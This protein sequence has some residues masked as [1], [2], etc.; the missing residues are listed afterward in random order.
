MIKK[1]ILF[2]LLFLLIPAFLNAQWVSDTLYYEFDEIEVT[3]TKTPRMLSEIPGRVDVL[4]AE[5]MAS[6]PAVNLVYQ[7]RTLSG[8]NTSGS[9]GLFT[10]SPNVTLRGLSGEEQSRTLVMMDG[11]PLNK[12]DTGGVNWNSIN[13]A[14]VKQVEVYK[15]PGSSLYGSNAMGGVI[16]IITKTPDSPFSANAGLSYGTYNTYQGNL[17]VS[18]KP[19]EKLTL[20]LDGFYVNSDGYISTPDS[21]RS[22]FDAARFVDEGGFSAKA[23]Y[24]FSELFNVQ[25]GYD[26]FLNKRGDGTQITGSGMYR[27]FDTNRARFNVRGEQD[28]F[29]Y[30]LNMFFQREDYF[31]VS[32]RMRNGDYS[33]FNVES[34]RD[35]WGV[36]LDLFQDTGSHSLAGGIEF[37]TGS[38]DGGDFYQTSDDVVINRGSMSYLSGY[39]Q[40]EI[41]MLDR[42]LFLQL[43]LRY[44]YV[45]FYDGFFEAT[46]PRLSGYN[47]ELD[48]NNWSTIS[49]RAALR[50]NPENRSFSGYISYA[51][52]FRASILDDLSR[53]GIL[54]GR[55]K[56]ANPELG[57]ETLD[58]FEIGMDLRPVW[59]MIIS[60]SLFYSHG[61]DF[62]Y[63]VEMPDD[64]SVFRRE[65]VSS[66]QIAGA[67]IDLRYFVSNAVTIT[68]SYTLH[69]SE[70]LSFPERP[71]MEGNQL[72]FT[73]R[74]QLKSSLNWRNRIADIGFT[75]LYKGS[76]Y[77]SDD[78][79]QKIDPYITF[80]IM[81]SRQ[82]FDSMR[83]SLEV[84]DIMDNRFMES[85]VDMS[86]GRFI[87]FK[88]GYE[89]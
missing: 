18:S 32:E 19:T 77:I 39:L 9:F 64:D 84:M 86:P 67:E 73:P 58:N 55:D 34:E 56:I 60:P 61:N 78:N 50:F 62:L 23:G 8:I 70:I 57:P 2:I 48:S 54:W 44:D 16:N 71:D 76:Q 89:W 14:N 1:L 24:R 13:T 20:H 83:V 42:R 40:D 17:N 3:A 74:H 66:V 30:A 79:S 53:T 21:L 49:P 41:N 87:N 65:N 80:D 43:G 7:L 69:H 25:A 88:V 27:K 28:R 26:L 15:G 10:M 12:S 82:I 11:M 38:V 31:R 75:T 45:T 4:S 5:V 35:D 59:N 46:T 63:F 81:A 68:G 72:T 29:R 36:S 52:G 22:D 51:R 6:V 85:I 47:G 33:R 37:K